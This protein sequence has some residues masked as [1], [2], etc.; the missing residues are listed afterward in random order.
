[1][2]KLFILEK[3]FLIFSKAEVWVPSYG[4][5]YFVLVVGAMLTAGVAMSAFSFYE[6]FYWGDKKF[7]DQLRFHP[8]Y[9]RR[10]DKES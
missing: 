1:M 7:R 10:M 5:L 3:L 9:R 2:E 4:F 6:D 8:S